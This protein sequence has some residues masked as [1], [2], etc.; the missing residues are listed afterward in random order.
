MSVE[1]PGVSGPGSNRHGT[2]PRVGDL[3]IVIIGHTEGLLA[4]KPLSAN[5]RN[6]Y[7]FAWR[8][9]CRTKAPALL[10]RH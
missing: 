6:S 5:A 1:F 4:T 10:G 2:Y 8:R 7:R 9:W 3:V